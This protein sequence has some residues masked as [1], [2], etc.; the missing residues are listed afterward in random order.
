MAQEI[1][2]LKKKQK[3]QKF[4]QAY[5]Q[6]KNYFATKKSFVENKVEEWNI[7]ILIF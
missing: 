7:Q 4:E 6:K 1:F 3:T 2:C 5:H